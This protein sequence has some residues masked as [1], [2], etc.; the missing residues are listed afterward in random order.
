MPK[1]D[2]SHEKYSKKDRE[3]RVSEPYAES[4]LIRWLESIGERECTQKGADFDSE[5]GIGI[6]IVCRR[7][8]LNHTT[9]SEH[10]DCDIGLSFAEP[11]ANHL[12]QVSRQLCTMVATK[13]VCRSHGRSGYPDVRATRRS[14]GLTAIYMIEEDK[15]CLVERVTSPLKLPDWLLRAG[16]AF[17]RP[18]MRD[19]QLE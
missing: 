6:M 15:S 3:F 4:A 8:E 14:H 10:S 7:E 11:F 18:E 1:V 13:D 2:G 12:A 9:G 19:T 17:A 5:D 16:L